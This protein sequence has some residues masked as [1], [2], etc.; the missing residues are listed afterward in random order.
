V[1]VEQLV[2]N[3]SAFRQEYLLGDDAPE[4]RAATL[5]LSNFIS[6]PFYSEMRTRQQLG[7]V[8]FGG[9]GDEERTNFAF[10]IIQSPEHAADEVQARAEAFIAQLPAMLAEL[11]DEAW[12]MLVA[13]CRAELEE[14]D[15]TIA[16]RAG[17][18]FNL[19]YHHGGDWGRRIDTLAALDTLTRE[20]AVEIL[21][22]AL[23]PET[24]RKRTFLGFARQ[25]AR[26]ES[27]ADDFADRE[28]W[29][30]G[31]TYQ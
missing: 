6:E 5:V 14:K 4:I 12:E 24:G 27:L 29:K 30:A 17:R 11:P 26:P 10:F 3:N 20:R 28:K 25:H 13:G 16:E 31:R 22:T 15:K 1:G 9:A 18:L 2:V 19:A 23:S 7:Y 21:S 8:V